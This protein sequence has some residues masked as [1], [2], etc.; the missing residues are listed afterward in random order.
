MTTY[1]LMTPGP[2]PLPKEVLD[3]LAR[4]MEHHRTPEFVAL[5]GRVLANLKQVFA[6]SEP[7]FI[8]TSTGSGGLESALVN[9]LSP[10]DHVLAIVSG[11][12]GERWAEMAE[13]FGVRVTRLEVEWGRAVRVTDV[14]DAMKKNPDLVA[15]MAQACE[16]STGVLHPIR[17]LAQLTKKS[18]AILIVDAITALGALPIPMDDWGIDVMVGGSQKAF[19]LPTGL[20]F[21]AFSK[22]A[23]ALVERSKM[24]KFYFDIRAERAANEN[25]ESLFSA[26]VTHVRALDLVLDIFLKHGLNK[27]HA[28]IAALS[29]ASIEAA[30]EMGLKVFPEISSPSVT[31]LAMPEGIDGQKIRADIEKASHIIVMGGQDRLKGKIVRIG[32]MGAIRDEDLLA[33]L[34]ALATSLNRAKPGTV[35]EDGLRA[36]LARAHEILK[37]TPAVVLKA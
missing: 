18:K 14:D 37:A 2:V 27:V 24:P 7:C 23:W 35:S 1:R 16:T 4:P 17:E 11:K 19:M 36:G 13:A 28:R 25:G 3:V 5:F 12:F 6:T 26:A 15:V 22:K 10:G 8:Q 30:R 31:A 33:T 34:E 20:T 32:N 29:R 21:I 9:T